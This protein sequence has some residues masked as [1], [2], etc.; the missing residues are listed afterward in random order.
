[1]EESFQ[2]V[3]NDPSDSFAHVAATP[4]NVWSNNRPSH[5]PQLIA[6]GKRFQWI[7]Y[8]ESASEPAASHLV[9]ESRKVNQT[10]PGNV[11]QGCAVR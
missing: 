2:I 9:F 8:V 11:D 7:C 5:R 3:D 1:M 6:N 4:G 10:S